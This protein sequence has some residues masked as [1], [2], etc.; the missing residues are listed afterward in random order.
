MVNSIINKGLLCD[1][2]WSDPDKNVDTWGPNDRGV[3]VTFSAS[4]I[5]NFLKKNDM[6]L[7][8]RAHQVGNFNIKH[9]FLTS[10]RL[11]AKNRYLFLKF[12]NIRFILVNFY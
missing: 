3:S 4:V 9:V 11:M 7:I 1:L 10:F 12:L 5:E 2:L 8:C 6:D